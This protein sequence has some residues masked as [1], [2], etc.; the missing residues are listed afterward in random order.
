[1]NKKIKELLKKIKAE[2]KKNNIKLHLRPS[3]YINCD[4]VP[5]GGVFYNSKREIYVATKKPLKKWLGILLHELSHAEQ[6]IVNSKYWNK[7]CKVKDEK[8]KVWD[9]SI[10]YFEWLAGSN[11]FSKK[12]VDKALKAIIMM[13]YECEQLAVAKIKKWDLEDLIDPKEYAQ[14]AMSY[15]LYYHASYARREWYRRAPYDIDS[16]YKK[17][18][19]N[20]DFSPETIAS[21]EFFEELGVDFSPC[22][23]SKKKSKQRA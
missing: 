13:E 21:T 17:I 10:I 8:G 23:V 1:M 22:F 15:V 4:G 6:M 18:P 7:A 16:V 12:T 3:Y 2:C 5:C 14:K 11:K 20:I 9:S 19:K